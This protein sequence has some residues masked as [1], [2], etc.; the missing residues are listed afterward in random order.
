MPN[1]VICNREVSKGS[2]SLKDKFELTGGGFICK[3][4]AQKIGIKNFMAAGAY[5]AQKARK[6]YFDLYPDEAQGND[7]LSAEYEAKLDEQF[8]TKFNAIQDC[9]P[10]SDAILRNLRHVL[11]EGEEVLH[12][13]MGYMSE[14]SMFLAIS[15]SSHNVW[16]AALTNIRVV[17]INQHI[18]GTDCVSFPLE[19]VN[20]VSCGSGIL[21][22]VVTI[23]QG[24]SCVILKNIKNKYAKT[25]T[26]KANE[27]IRAR[28]IKQVQGP[29]S[30]PASAADELAKWHELL[31]KGVITQDE[32]DNQKNR[33]LR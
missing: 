29:K 25:F 9:E 22:S 1:C 7:A 19:T 16:L 2:F 18:T 23:S 10:R 32:Y 13:V 20:S 6:K 8:I 12:A 5:T 26:V 28:R 33:I 15:K 11:D 27:A 4:C 24:M 21:D 30:V 14:D 17:L 3:T 31:S